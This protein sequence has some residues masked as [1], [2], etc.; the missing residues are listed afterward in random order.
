MG[1]Y[2]DKPGVTHLYRRLMGGVSEAIE[3]AIESIPD[4]ESDGA[5]DTLFDTEYKASMTVEQGG[6][7]VTVTD[8][9]HFG[10]GCAS[11]DE[12]T[13]IMKV[14]GAAIPVDQNDPEAGVIIVIS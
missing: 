7:Q 2:L 12:D 4:F 5:I 8:V 14:E 11:F 6:Q 13:G 3:D 10:N 9:I 1:K